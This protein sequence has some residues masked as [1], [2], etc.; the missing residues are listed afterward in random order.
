MPGP[1]SFES[2]GLLVLAACALLPLAVH[3]LGRRAKRPL[4]F[5]ALSFLLR[6]QANASRTLRLRK[7]LLFCARTLLLA[8]IPLALAKPFLAESVHA[9]ATAQ[10]GPTATVIAVDTSLSMRAAG[11]NGEDSASTAR[12]LALRYLQSLPDQ[13]PV[14]V[15]D[16]APGSPAPETPSFDR[17]EAEEALRTISPGWKH[18]PLE[19]CL[20]RAGALL[21]RSALTSKRLAVA[22]DFAR[23]SLR[24]TA[25]GTPLTA[26]IPPETE[27]VLLDAS[28]PPDEAANLAV[29]RL[30]IAPVQAPGGRTFRFSAAIQNFSQR[31]IRDGVL[32]LRIGGETVA[33]SFFDLEPGGS[34]VRT[35]THRFAA[36][37]DYSGQVSIGPDALEADNTF[38]FTLGVPRKPSVLIVNGSP[39]PDRLQDEAFF[40]QAALDAPLG[41]IQAA[42]CDALSA[43]LGDLDH[44]DAVFLLNAGSVTEREAEAVK[45]FVRSGGGLFIS[46]GDHID[47]D[48]FNERWDSL[49]PRQLR[50][51]KTAE[52]QQTAPGSQNGRQATR[53]AHIDVS[54]PALDVFAKEDGE[55]LRT[56]RFFRYFLTE[57]VRGG[58]SAQS[59][60]AG[61][62]QAPEQTAPGGRILAAFEDGAPAFIAGEYGQGR[63]LL[64]TSSVDRSWTD[65]PIRTGFLPL[66][67]RVAAFLAR[68][69]EDLHP[70]PVHTG[71]PLIL[72]A[73]ASALAREALLPDGTRAPLT[74]PTSAQNA[75]QGLLRLEDTPQPGVYRLYGQPQGPGRTAAP[76]RG[77]RETALPQDEA[78]D[79]D[80]RALERSP[81]VWLPRL[82]AAVNVDIQ[83]SDLTKIPLEHLQ[84]ILGSDKVTQLSSRN[85]DRSPSRS[86]GLPPTSALLLLAALCF[87]AEC[88]LI[89]R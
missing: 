21:E 77:E 78:E 64:F 1:L 4:P 53:L 15:L 36:P 62:G 88:L 85:P 87:A 23:T 69:L 86:H 8:A 33:K 47:A 74:S 16:C 38:F 30:T 26:G 7:I 84:Q 60:N 73:A 71:E 54:H 58:P 35:L 31:P 81:L 17:A 37:G 22:S 25:D 59:A 41:G 34:A 72:P 29:T 6:S 80:S 65:F 68:S 2:P 82:D 70:A 11:A 42:Q 40:V 48:A 45:A 20:S 76:R 32:S 49:S 63:V 39:S 83:E 44:F 5:A 51:V 18:Q 79:A 9:P 10:H 52:A 12:R 46:L 3:L 61:E 57:N 67:Q 89:K 43:R 75:E 27:W 13:D 55:G 56:A 28:L 66:M 14:A 19:D 50:L 24:L